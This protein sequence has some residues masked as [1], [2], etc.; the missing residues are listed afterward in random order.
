MEDAASYLAMASAYFPALKKEFPSALR[1]SA[2]GFGIVGD[3]I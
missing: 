3:I 2:C 1:A